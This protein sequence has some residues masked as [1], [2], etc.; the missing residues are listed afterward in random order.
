[1]NDVEREERKTIEWGK[2]LFH[3]RRNHAQIVDEESK[4]VHGWDIGA[5]VRIIPA[6]PDKVDV[7]IIR[8]QTEPHVQGWHVVGTA[9]APMNTPAYHWQM[10]GADT[11]AWVIVPAGA[12]QNWCVNSVMS[13]WIDGELVVTC[14]TASR[15]THV[16]TKSGLLAESDQ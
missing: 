15:H 16:V 9:K 10:T 4:I 14:S 8:A 1:M 7:K 6:R 11:Q 3:I 13:S 12:D 2:A 5:N